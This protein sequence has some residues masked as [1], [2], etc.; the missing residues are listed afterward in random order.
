MG[1]SQASELPRGGDE[2]APEERGGTIAV[3]TPATGKHT[4][5]T[6]P[7]NAMR[8]VTAS[9]PRVPPPR[10]LQTRVLL[11]TRPT[12]TWRDARGRRPGAH[13]WL[14]HRTPEARSGRRPLRSTHLVLVLATLSLLGGARAEPSSITPGGEGGLKG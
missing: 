7:A 12:P 10:A 13:R 6:R 11:A 4:A 9:A 3:T 14:E 5:A 8:R 1:G 2:L